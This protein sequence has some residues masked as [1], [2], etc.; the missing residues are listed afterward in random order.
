VH[1]IVQH[2]LHLQSNQLRKSRH[3]VCSEPTF[4]RHL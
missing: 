1:L 3:I 4:F 2:T